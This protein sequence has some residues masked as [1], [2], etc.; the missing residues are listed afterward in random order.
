[1]KPARVAASGK[2]IFTELDVG[3]QCHKLSVNETG[4]RKTDVIPCISKK[5]KKNSKWAGW[6]GSYYKSSVL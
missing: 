2:P 6:F 5:L 3:A 1:M 4:L